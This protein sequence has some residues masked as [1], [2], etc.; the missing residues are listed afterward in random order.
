VLAHTPSHCQSCGTSLEGVLPCA[1]E[2]RQVF[3][4]PPLRLWVTEHQA[5][6][7]RCLRCGEQTQGTFP[8]GIQEPVQYGARI[9]ALGVYLQQ[10]QLLPYGRT[11]ELLE[12]LFG[13]A[14]CAATLGQALERASRAL[15]GV[16]AQIKQAICG[17]PV[18]HFDETGIRAQAQ[19]QWLHVAATERLTYYGVHAK[20]GCAALD[21]LAL[22][23]GLRGCAVHDAYASYLSYAGRHALCNAHL[24]RELL[25]L[26]EETREPWP[27]ALILLL[28]EMKEQVEAAR[29]AGDDALPAERVQALRARYERILEYGAGLHPPPAPTG[30]KG[31]RKQSRARNLLDRLERHPEKVLAF[32]Y[33]LAVPFDNNLAERDLRMAKVQQ[34]ISGGFR[35]TGGAALFCRIRGYIST[36]RKQGTHVLTALE[37]VFQGHPYVPLLSPG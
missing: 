31:R 11:R 5:Q 19:L 18:V 37:S 33:D 27:T 4:L 24:L 28:L 14:P 9:L 22:L 6:R 16:E 7:I 12:D 23:P 13:A 20:R 2:C 26:E 8:P 32:L 1:S 35:S 3:D 25:A 21:A 15:E 17:A 29:A 30:K 34:K 10:Y 36:L